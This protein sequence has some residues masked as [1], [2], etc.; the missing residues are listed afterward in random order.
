MTR[1]LIFD[2]DGVIIHREGYFSDRLSRDFG[3][4][5]EKILPFFKNEFQQCLLGKADLK[6]EIQKY[7]PQ[8][9]WEKSLDELLEFWFSQESH[10]DERL[11]SDISNLRQKGIRCYL[12]T[13]NEK[14]RVEYL[15]HRLGF[16]DLFDKIFASSSVGFLKQST[17]FWSVIFSQLNVEKNEVLVWDDEQI[18]VD[19]ARGFGFPAELY[20]DFEL[21]K[22]KM[23]SLLTS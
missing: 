21:Y 10:L 7:L 18:A 2:A 17:D 22:K 15:S 5:L 16:K 6:Q 12:A 11:V 1:A 4:P 14:H 3:I 23:D 13:V 8:W 20:T 19:A 9:G